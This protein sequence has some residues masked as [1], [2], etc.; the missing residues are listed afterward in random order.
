MVREKIEVLKGEIV[1]YAS[2]IENMIDKSIKGLTDK[3]KE[4]LVSVIEGDEPN[5]NNHE[6]EIEEHCVELIAQ[7]QPKAKD[8][9]IVLMILKM[10]NDLERMGDHAV[11][12]AESSAF[13]IERPKVKTLF[14]LTKLSN[15]T[16]R[17]LND[18]I[19]TFINE[20]ASKA[21]E[22]C[23]RDSIVDD[24]RDK[25]LRELIENMIEDP[26]TIERNM[27]LLR[28]TKNLERIADL[29]TNISE[30][31]IYMVE[32]RVIKHHKENNSG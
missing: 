14:E 6:I 4:N 2:L 25:I 5:A 11:N 9:R 26:A 30:D 1:D 28:I 21:K 3:N 10:N 23:E 32:G 19:N 20:D 13:L 12:I 24:L 17:M 27:H 15:E 7:F 16:K 18:S 29:S 22:V 8:L 31:T